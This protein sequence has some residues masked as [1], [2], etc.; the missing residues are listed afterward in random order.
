MF[1]DEAAGA[2]GDR[3]G[4]RRRGWS[5]SSAYLPIGDVRGE[6]LLIYQEGTLLG[7]LMTQKCYMD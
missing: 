7:A 3:G 4:A 1:T 2:E 6:G 5:C